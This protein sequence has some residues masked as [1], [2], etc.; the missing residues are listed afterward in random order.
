VGGVTQSVEP[1][2]GEFVVYQSKEHGLASN[3]KKRKEGLRR[4]HLLLY[5][6]KDLRLAMIKMVRYWQ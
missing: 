4:C 3:M 2:G 1:L 5:S 6:S